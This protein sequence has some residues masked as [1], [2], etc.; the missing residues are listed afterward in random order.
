MIC[1]GAPLSEWLAWLETLSPTEIDLGLERVQTVLGRLDLATPEHVLLIAGTNGKGS[2]AAMATALLR[3]SGKRVGT[4]TSPHIER[5]NERIAID[6]VACSDEAI[7]AAF[8]VVESAR[9][10]V[11]L[12]YFE[13]GT[14]AATVVFAAAKLDVW[15]LE[16]GL[17]G[18]LDATNAIEPS[19][20]L[21]TNV[22]LDH[23]DWLGHD[24]ESIAFEKAGVMRTGMPTI[25]GGPTLP[26]AIEQHG[27][28]IGSQC[29]SAGR[30]FGVSILPNDAW[31]WRGF[32]SKMFALAPPGLPGK[33]QVANAAA[34][35]ALLEATGLLSDID[36]QLVNS[37][38]P[39]ISLAGR[40]QRLY[41]G[42]REWWIDVAH[43]PAAAQALATTLSEHEINGNT[44]AIVGVLDDKDVEGI[45]EPITAQVDAWVAIAPNNNRSLPAAGLARQIA[46]LTGCACL[47]AASAAE[48]IEFSRRS[49]AESDRI[50]VTGSF[51]TVGPILEL[52]A[53]VPRPKT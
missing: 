52:L 21:I 18:R 27:L 47:V 41:V 48:A 16:V 30:D 10:E 7:I 29:F 23:C 17:G 9:K 49:S 3:A 53:T 32:A 39:K 25:F 2:C 13:F 50:L 38:L 8:E 40:S 35:L 19:G 31:H 34:V 12:T 24:V 45:I 20:S 43:N 42:G 5:Y 11:A 4:Y 36:S 28:A 6:N 14:L 37:V 44:T 22:S 33:F 51:F 15:V 46:N 26:K 1:A